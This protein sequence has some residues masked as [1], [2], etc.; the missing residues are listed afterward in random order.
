LLEMARDAF[1]QGMTNMGTPGQVN[2]PRE[3]DIKVDVVQGKGNSR[4]AN[5]PRFKITGISSPETVSAVIN[6]M[7][8]IEAERLDTGPSM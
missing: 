8:E 4:L 7:Q 3:M 6:E 1:V 5:G 2:F